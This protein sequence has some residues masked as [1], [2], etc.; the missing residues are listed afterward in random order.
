MDRWRYS[1]GSGYTI[2][3]YLGAVPAGAAETGSSSSRLSICLPCRPSTVRLSVQC[4]Y[5]LSITC[6]PQTRQ[7][8]L[9]LYWRPTTPEQHLLR[10]DAV[11]YTR[12]SFSEQRGS[13][14]ARKHSVKPICPIEFSVDLDKTP[15]KHVRFC[16]SGC[17]MEVT[18]SAKSP[19][20]RQK[21]I[22]ACRGGQRGG[23]VAIAT[24]IAQVR[25]K[26]EE[27]RAS[28]QT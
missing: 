27:V 23:G 1:A 4:C 16:G 7:Q 18:A 9:L 5:T 10:T 8:W 26:E 3:H 17:D 28:C 21:V 24:C 6:A 14:Y 22:P 19:T 12:V 13:I 25:R 2:I 15:D 20:P 11:V